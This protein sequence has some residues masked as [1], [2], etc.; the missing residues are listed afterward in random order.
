MF[1]RYNPVTGMPIYSMLY[2][3]SL[4]DVEITASV[5]PWY[6]NAADNILIGKDA[7]F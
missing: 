3:R 7:T 2:G 1:R 6:D 4:G 5:C